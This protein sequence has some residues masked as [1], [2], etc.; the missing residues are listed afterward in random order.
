MVSMVYLWGIARRAGIPDGSDPSSQAPHWSGGEALVSEVVLGQRCDRISRLRRHSAHTPS[1]RAPMNCVRPERR[2]TLRADRRL[3]G[4]PAVASGAR[5][6]PY[7]WALGRACGRRPHPRTLRSSRVLRSIPDGC[8]LSCEDMYV[9]FDISNTF[10][11]LVHRHG[12]NCSR[13]LNRD[14]SALTRV[15]KVC[16]CLPRLPIVLMS[17]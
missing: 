11:S 3:C 7:P 13:L 6:R 10:I 9:R 1:G 8:A 16:V 15:F 12:S 17:I 14:V 5:A 2:T 4:G